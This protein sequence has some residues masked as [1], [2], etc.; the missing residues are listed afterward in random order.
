MEKKMNKMISVWFKK[1]VDEENILKWPEKGIHLKL[2]IK[3]C[4]TVSYSFIDKND[5]IMYGTGI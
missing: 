4:D 1:D 5:K 2:W 3:V